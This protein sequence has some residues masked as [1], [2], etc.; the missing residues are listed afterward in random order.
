MVPADPATWTHAPF[1]GDIDDD[2]VVWGR[3]AVDNKHN[4]LAQLYAANHLISTGAMTAPRRTIYFAFGHDEEIGGG[5]GARVIAATLLA[6]GVRAEF[7][8]D[9]G[10]FAVT[11]ILP[12]ISR[13]IAL[14]CHC[15]KGAVDLQ[16]TADCYPPGH[17]SAPPAE[18]NI[19]V[20]ARAINRLEARPF[21]I[22]TSLVVDGLTYIA[23]DLPLAH[24]VVLANMTLFGPIVRWFA[25]KDAKVCHSLH[26]WLSQVITCMSLPYSDAA[27][28]SSMRMHHCSVRAAE[29]FYYFATYQMMLHVQECDYSYVQALETAAF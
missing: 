6:R 10:A 21:P 1:A 16:I 13:P 3:G 15:E 7:V 20:L 4:V 19:G 28:F 24:R 5:E 12:G 17:S 23:S 11:N 25:S 27:T 18:S 14:I 8:L 22:D 26:P 2:G 29:I 9:E